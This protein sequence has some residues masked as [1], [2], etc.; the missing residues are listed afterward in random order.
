MTLNPIP[1]DGEYNW[2][3]IVTSAGKTGVLVNASISL[4]LPYTQR[5]ITV[6]FDSQNQS[7]ALNSTTEFVLFQFDQID[8]QTRDYTLKVVFTVVH[9]LIAP[10]FSE[11]TETI[12]KTETVRIMSTTTTA[13]N[14][15]GN[16]FVLSHILSVIILT[17][18]FFM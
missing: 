11:T 10:I 5:N 1:G 15:T 17:V 16:R 3:Q 13:A 8:S 18:L 7:Y 12:T 14:G 4:E 2:K 9:A 6:F